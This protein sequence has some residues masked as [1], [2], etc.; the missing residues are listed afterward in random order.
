M[1]RGRWLAGS[2]NIYNMC[3]PSSTPSYCTFSSLPCPLPL[4]PT[5]SPPF[6]TFHDFGTLS[7]GGSNKGCLHEDAHDDTWPLGPLSEGKNLYSFF[8]SKVEVVSEMLPTILLALPFPVMLTTL[9]VNAFRNNA[10]PMHKHC[11][12]SLCYLSVSIKA[13]ASRED[14]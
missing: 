3:S 6:T 12:F 13:R 10:G 1:A 2:L 14:G 11:L 5:S 4:R 7:Q 8:F 9:A